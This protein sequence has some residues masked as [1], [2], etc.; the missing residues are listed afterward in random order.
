[1]YQWW[2]GG[3]FERGFNARSAA[4]RRI[5]TERDV[6]QVRAYADSAAC[7][8]SLID[9][10]RVC[11]DRIEDLEGALKAANRLLV[12]PMPTRG[13]IAIGG[14]ASQKPQ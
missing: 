11:Y 1:M 8:L 7:E 12:S 6:I 3:D 14:E 10:E 9:T 13:E 4:C 2:Y 5:E